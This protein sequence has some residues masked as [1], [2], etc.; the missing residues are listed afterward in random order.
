M[1]DDIRTPTPAAMDSVQKFKKKNK[2]NNA[3]AICR[4]ILSYTNDC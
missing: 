3:S 1:I 2:M 4:N